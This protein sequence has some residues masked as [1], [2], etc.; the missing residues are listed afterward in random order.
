MLGLKLNHVSKRGHRRSVLLTKGGK[1]FHVMTLSCPSLQHISLSRLQT[2][3]IS[4]EFISIAANENAFHSS[5]MYG[6]CWCCDD[7]DDGDNDYFTFHEEAVVFIWSCT[8][9]TQN[10]AKDACGEMQYS[11]FHSVKHLSL[12]VSISLACV[13]YSPSSAFVTIAYIYAIRLF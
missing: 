9:A 12:F 6:R 4:N 11:G 2:L 8:L 13:C 1:R 3:S 10:N 5:H 7:I